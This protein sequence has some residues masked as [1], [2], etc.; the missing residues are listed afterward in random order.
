MKQIDTQR[1]AG[2]AERQDGAVGWLQLRS[3]GLAEG[4][5]SRLVARGLLHRKFPGAYAFGHPHLTQRGW[6][7][8]AL[9]ACGP[10]AILVDRTAAAARSL[11]PSTSTIQIGIVGRHGATIAGLDVRRY[12]L[13]PAARTVHHGLP[14]T[15]LARTALDVAASSPADRLGT[16]LDRALMDHRYDHGEM[17]ALLEHRRGCRGVGRLRLAVAALADHPAAFRSL[18]E[19]RA[20]DHLVAAGVAAPAVNAWLPTRAGHG[21]ELDLWWPDLRLDVEVDGPHHRFPHQ[22]RKDALRDADLLAAGVSVL[23][24]PTE[25][26]NADPEGFV[27][28][29]RRATATLSGDLLPPL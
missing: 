15:S 2:L 9:L 22:Q 3:M 13:H 16:L 25:A 17:L 4:S 1:V 24:F 6:W 5:V 29:V 10:G 23:R 18:D 7:W 27:T 11:L 12:D 8:A 20:R 19:R 21:H 26:I 28:R 14:L